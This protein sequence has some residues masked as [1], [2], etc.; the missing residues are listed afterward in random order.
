M[1][2]APLVR[3][4]EAL[5]APLE[6]G[7]QDAW[8]AESLIR[9]RDVGGVREASAAT[10]A[11]ELE[12][13]L[14]L[15]G[16]EP[17]W[18]QAALDSAG[19]KPAGSALPPL[20]AGSEDQLPLLSMRC[21][22]AAGL[23]ILYRLDQW[24]GT[25]GQVCDD[26]SAGMAIFR[27]DGVREMARNARWSELLDEEPERDRL[28]EV[29][30]RQ[31]GHTAAS[32]GPLRED[33]GELELSGRCY[34]LI[35]KRA[36]AGTL[37]PE[38][39]VLVLIDRLGPELPTTRELRVSFG[40]QGREPQVALLAAEGLSNAAIAQRLRLS[41]HTVRHYLERVL[42]RLGLHSRNALALHLMGAEREKPPAEE[43]SAAASSR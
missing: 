4:V 20:V 7:S 35:A 33:Y 5:M 19:G 36:P 8:L 32:V 27:R 23:A 1:D 26:V 3:A 37:L 13:L 30:T 41:A 16:D 29:I 14:R 24:R 6:W 11:G 2:L 43:G 42:G 39:G 17:G 25:L 9:V 31:A 12:E 10:A 22:L 28:L 34:R 38:A 15:D 18:L 21:G 40:L